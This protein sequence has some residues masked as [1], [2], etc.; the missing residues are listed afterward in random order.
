MNTILSDIPELLSV[1]GLLVSG[2]GL[3]NLIF[4]VRQKVSAN[5]K[6]VE[7]LKSLKRAEALRLAKILQR[8][9]LDP[10]ECEKILKR[11]EGLLED[12]LDQASWREIHEALNQRSTRGRAKYAASLL[13]K[14]ADI[15]MA[16]H[17]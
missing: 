9:D 1:L 5:R 15:E 4:K 13:N 10:I 11:I 14:S 2:M 12:A 6:A 8:E 7:K 3:L 17:H 16:A